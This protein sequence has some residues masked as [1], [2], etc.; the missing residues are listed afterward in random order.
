MGAADCVGLDVDPVACECATLNAER[1]ALP[2]RVVC[3]ALDGLPA[4]ARYDVVVAN[5]LLARLQPWL[6]RLVAHTG[7][8]LILSGVLAEEADAL[9]VECL[10]AG[11]RPDAER[12]ES[13]SGETWLAA[14]WVHLDRQ[15]SSSSRSV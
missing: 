5:M 15:E 8:T 7:R 1:N 12:T 4:E 9:R 14:R 10:A 11:L 13:S 2:L 3:T 6:D